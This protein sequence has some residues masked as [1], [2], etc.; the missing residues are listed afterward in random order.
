[1]KDEE[2]K[3]K[4]GPKAQQVKTMEMPKV[5]APK[6]VCVCPR[7][8]C[9]SVCAPKCMCVCVCAQG[10]CVS[11]RTCVRLHACKVVLGV[12][13]ICA[14]HAHCMLSGWLCVDLLRQR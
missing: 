14:E 5:C 13:L 12:L 8:V 4:H 3:H 1:M 2:Q 7:C 10:V 9:S 6:C 11:V